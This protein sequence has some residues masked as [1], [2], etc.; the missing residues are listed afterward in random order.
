M[1][2]S[3]Y[4]TFYQ[5]NKFFVNILFCTLEVEVLNSLILKIT[6]KENDADVSVIPAAIISINLSL[7]TNVFAGR[8]WPV[9]WKPLQWSN[10]DNRAT[11]RCASNCVSQR[12]RSLLLVRKRAN[13]FRCRFI[14]NVLKALIARRGLLCA[15]RCSACRPIYGRA[16]LTGDAVGAR[17]DRSR[18]IYLDLSFHAMHISFRLLCNDIFVVCCTKW[19]SFAFLHLMHCVPFWENDGAESRPEAKSCCHALA[20]TCIGMFAF[21]STCFVSLQLVFRNVTSPTLVDSNNICSVCAIL[22]T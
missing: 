10:E 4:F 19:L 7:L 15:G 5:V 8:T 17:C 20:S 12:A 11:C 16:W 22:S 18:F 14:T 9:V 13:H 2:V 1:I 21:D 6:A 3:G